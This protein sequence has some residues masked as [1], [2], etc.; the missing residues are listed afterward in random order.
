VYR[1]TKYLEQ[2]RCALC[3]KQRHGFIVTCERG[4][5]SE[6]P[7]CLKCLERQAALQDQPS[8]KSER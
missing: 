2:L 6:K 1:L 8:A 3:G 5:F 4:T 7:L